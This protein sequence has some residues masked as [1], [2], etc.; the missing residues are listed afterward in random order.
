MLCNIPNIFQF[1]KVCFMAQNMDFLYEDFM[2]TWKINEYS[3]AIEY[4]AL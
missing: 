2:C 3:E 4:S 1:I